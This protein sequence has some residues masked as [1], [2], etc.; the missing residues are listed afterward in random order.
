MLINRP[1]TAAS[2]D[3]ID[4]AVA[5]APQTGTARGLVLL[6][7]VLIPGVIGLTLMITG[8]VLGFRA[9]DGIRRAWPRLY[10][11]GSAVVGAWAGIL[12]IANAAILAVTFGFWD[13]P[14]E[15]PPQAPLVAT[16]LLLA[17]DVAF[18]VWYRRR[19]LKRC[20]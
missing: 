3:S 18:L 12:L 20:R 9:L 13:V 5:G 6:I 17:S 16:L 1:P 7:V 19:F 14:G 4:E 10:G 15:I 2:S 8:S 11:A